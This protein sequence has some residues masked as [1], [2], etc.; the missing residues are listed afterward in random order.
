MQIAPSVHL[1]TATQPETSR[2][3]FT[4]RYAAATTATLVAI[5]A[6]HLV[7]PTAFVVLLA[8]ITLTGV[9][10][11][12]FLRH[13]E[14]RIGAVR[15]PRPLW[16]SLTVLSAV[17]M[18]AYYVFWT[19]RDFL[20]P[21]NGHAAQAFA[22]RFGPSEVVQ[23]LMQVF[24]LFA[25]FRS[26]SLISDKDATLATV[27]SFS[28]LLLLIPLHKEGVEVVIYFLVWSVVASLLFALDHRSDL[29]AGATAFVP[30]LS[31]GQDARLAA[32][33]LATVL[34][35]SLAASTGFSYYLT[36][37]NAS[38]RSA[39]EDAINS[40]VSR[41]TSI[42]LSLPE[43]TGNGGPE[44][45]I[46]FTARPSLP[47]STL[48]WEGRA[49]TVEGTPIRPSY[50]RMFTLDT[51]NGVSWVQGVESTVRVQ[52]KYV[53][54]DRWPI[55][56]QFLNFSRESM[57]RSFG[58]TFGFNSGFSRGNVTRRFRSGF[59]MERA[60]PRLASQF[61]PPAVA[62]HQELR[63]QVTGVGFVPVLPAPRVAMLRGSDQNEIRLRR[64]GGV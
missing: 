16:N 27:P 19:L 64:D 8:C 48:L 42:A 11:S 6:A 35:I 37:R 25:A 5:A 33:S 56:Q 45:Q 30:P 50:W 34:G 52:R 4:L 18:S 14:M 7:L 23:L 61:G 59:D 21:M 49:W 46:D 24:L 31:P 26:F 39:A 55:P 2:W 13:S 29:R 40:L 51:Y 3:E 60:A 41:I 9:P 1:T 62:V 17:L 47:S 63:A 44:R 58:P 53:T 12:L 22:L 54:P 36:S 38:E 32:R 20:V 15:V 10:V 28:V 43:G 57:G